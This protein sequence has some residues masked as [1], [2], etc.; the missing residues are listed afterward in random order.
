MMNPE[1]LDP[2]SDGDLRQ[3]AALIQQQFDAQ[4]TV[5]RLEAQLKDANETLRVIAEQDLPQAMLACG[6]NNFTTDSGLK[7]KI[8]DKFRCG[9]LDD[10]PE[11]DDGRPLTDRLA[12][13][14]WLEEH[15]HGDLAKR[16]VSVILGRASLDDAVRL[17]QLIRS[18]PGGN[19]LA[20]D[21]RRFVPWNTLS[22]FARK[23]VQEGYDPPMD[24][25]GITRIQHA[26]V[27]REKE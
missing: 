6:V 27:T 13:L 5:A 8:E 1:P 19:Q 9:Q 4:L 18:S 7:V 12:A 21:H 20:I 22:S 15:R 11:K 24:L 25:L 23:Q 3:V 2:P 16:V 17:I 26:K 10:A 14:T